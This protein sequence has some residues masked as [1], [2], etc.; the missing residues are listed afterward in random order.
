MPALFQPSPILQVQHLCLHLSTLKHRREWLAGA[1]VATDSASVDADC[2]NGITLHGP[3]RAR[4]YGDNAAHRIAREALY[5]PAGFTL[6]PGQASKSC[7][8]GSLAPRIAARLSSL[9]R[10]SNHLQSKL[11]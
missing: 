1:V 2:D 4:G 6:F 5:H 3:P 8:G 10:S 7:R 11:L 9:T